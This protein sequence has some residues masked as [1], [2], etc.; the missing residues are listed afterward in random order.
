MPTFRE[1]AEEFLAQE[2]LAVIGVSRGGGQ[3]ANLIY[4]KLR[5]QGYQVFPVNPNADVVEG[6][7][8]YANLGAVPG[9]LDGVVV[10]SRPAVAEEVV[11]DCVELG[12][13]RVWMHENGLFGAGAS[14]VSQ[15]AVTYG[16]QNGIEI[17]AGGCPLMF[18]DFGHKCMRWVLGVMGRLP[19]G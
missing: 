9:K 3:A 8:C 6:D 17:I 15:E 10:V 19:E 4:Q 18:L 5:D 13:P 2:R 16:K 1:A 12:V 11:R 14:S 7:T